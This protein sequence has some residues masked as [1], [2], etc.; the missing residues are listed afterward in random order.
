MAVYPA[1]YASESERKMGNAVGTSFGELLASNPMVRIRDR[2]V[3]LQ[4]ILKKTAPFP[5]SYRKIKALNVGIAP[6]VLTE[7]IELEVGRN[8]CALGGA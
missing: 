5:E 3:F 4:A 1:H 2:E 7:V 6:I 8:E